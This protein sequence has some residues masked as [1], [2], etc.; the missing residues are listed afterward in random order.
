MYSSLYGHASHPHAFPL[1]D[2]NLDRTSTKGPQ[3]PCWKQCLDIRKQFWFNFRGYWGA[4][5][6]TS[7]SKRKGNSPPSPIKQ[8]WLLHPTHAV[9]KDSVCVKHTPSTTEI[10]KHKF[11]TK[12]FAFYGKFARDCRYFRIELKFRHT[13]TP[14][15]S[16]LVAEYS[17][18]EMFLYQKSTPG[19]PTK[20]SPAGVMKS[21]LT[22]TPMFHSQIIELPPYNFWSNLYLVVKWPNS[23]S[24]PLQPGQA[25]RIILTSL[26]Q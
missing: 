16:S 12:D 21:K 1:P 4:S 17:K 5:N 25:I 15:E 20:F 24:P 14:D 10:R 26:S 8:G 13:A 3:W 7:R 11:R 2:R 18:F 6:R 9:E 22:P 23:Y 19:F